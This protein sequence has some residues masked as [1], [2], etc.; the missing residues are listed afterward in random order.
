M[1]Y[2]TKVCLYISIITLGRIM[3]LN[4][5]AQIFRPSNIEKLLSPDQQ[6][7]SSVKSTSKI[8]R[9]LFVFVNVLNYI[10][11]SIYHICFPY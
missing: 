8:L 2:Y 3:Y 9:S 5:V 4:E 1:I 6:F 11:P 10:T 7:F